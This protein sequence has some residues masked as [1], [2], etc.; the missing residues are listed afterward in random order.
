MGL[1]DF[2]KGGE[3]EAAASEIMNMDISTE[4]SAPL[5][6]KHLVYQAAGGYDKVCEARGKPESIEKAQ[7]MMSLFWTAF[8]AKFI[9][10]GVKIDNEA[11]VKSEAERLSKQVLID[12]GE[13]QS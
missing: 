5:V 2:M 10:N 3:H 7:E 6:A 1:A 9:E 4:L 13:Y 12:S 8:L 11:E